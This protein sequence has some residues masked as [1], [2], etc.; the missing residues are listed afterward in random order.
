MVPRRILVV[1]DEPSIAET[2][3]W[4]LRDEGYSVR[5]ARNGREALDQV[6]SELPDLVI[7]DIMMPIMD[8]W[9]L[10]R[11]LHD[12]P[13]TSAIPVVITT[14][15][16]HLAE[17]GGVPFSAYLAKPF[18]IDTLAETIARALET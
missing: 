11:A 15:L 8:G 18:D 17:R 1:D 3:G 13:A 2:V 10:C 5:F 4:V 14:A 12:D 16:P 6:R 9:S 7:T